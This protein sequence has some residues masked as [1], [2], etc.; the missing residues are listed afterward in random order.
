M[1][2]LPGRKLNR[3]CLTRNERTYE[4]RLG[5]SRGS[6]KSVVERRYSLL[7]GATLRR[8]GEREGIA[9]REGEKGTAK[10]L[11]DESQGKAGPWMPMGG[12]PACEAC[13]R[14]WARGLWRE[15]GG[16]GIGP[17]SGEEMWA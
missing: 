7:D 17:G 16:R 12:V 2:L 10:I 15:G 4:R 6:Q 13:G 14:M 11:R 3:Y 8:A 5:S 9:R 1:R